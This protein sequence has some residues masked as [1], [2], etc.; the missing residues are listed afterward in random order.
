LRDL[1]LYFSAA[2]DLREN[3]QD[4]MNL[5]FNFHEGF[6]DELVVTN[7]SDWE[8]AMLADNHYSRRTVGAKRFL[9]AGRKLVIRNR[10]ATVLFG[11]MWMY[12]EYRDDGQTG[13]N[14]AIFHNES[15]RRASEI[16]LECEQIAFEKW[17]PNRVYT[18]VN[19]RK[20]R[21]TRQPGRC[22]LKAGW[23]YVRDEN[24]DPYRSGKGLYLLAKERE[25]EAVCPQPRV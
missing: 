15:A 3:D 24:G 6:A 1:L 14:C 9:Y 12:D 20:I 4:E 13:Y 8:M 7:E 16:I 25:L 22:F 21:P 19:A 18:Y 5:L 11:W 2:L 10:A 23:H 17:G